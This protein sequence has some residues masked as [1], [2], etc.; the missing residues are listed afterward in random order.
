MNFKALDF[1]ARMKNF[2]RLTPKKEIVEIMAEEYAG[3]YGK[4]KKVFEKM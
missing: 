1:D 4:N 3:H 2:S